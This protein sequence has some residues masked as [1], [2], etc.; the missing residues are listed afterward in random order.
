[1]FGSS[2]REVGYTDLIPSR[3][4]QK[5]TFFIFFH[6]YKKSEHFCGFFA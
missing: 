4:Q 6:F 5:T 1:M 2:R 3:Q